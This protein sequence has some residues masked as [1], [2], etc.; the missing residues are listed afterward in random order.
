MTTRDNSF[1]LHFPQNKNIIRQDAFPQFF[2]AFS[3]IQLSNEKYITLCDERCNLFYSLPLKFNTV[4]SAN[5]L[6]ISSFQWKHVASL[7]L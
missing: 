4:K 2:S 7:A 6:A 3:H 5:S 1:F